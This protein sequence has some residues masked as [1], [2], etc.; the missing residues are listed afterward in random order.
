MIHGSCADYRAAA[1]VDLALDEADID[2]QVS[3]PTLALWGSGG[4]MHQ[5]FDMASLWR[6]RCSNLRAETLP[7]AH[8]FVDEH[9]KETAAVLTDFLT[10]AT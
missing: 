5:C 8:F 9:P 10:T 6:K 7:G 4:F 2:R 1:T 3:C